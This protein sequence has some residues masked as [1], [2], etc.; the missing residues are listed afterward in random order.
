M[1]V[2]RSATLLKTVARMPLSTVKTPSAMLSSIVAAWI[3]D[4]G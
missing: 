2:P 1:A 4:I 3:G